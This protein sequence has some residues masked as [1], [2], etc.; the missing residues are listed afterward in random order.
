[1]NTLDLTQIG[2]QTREAVTELVAAAQLKPGQI[3][4]VG[5]STSEVRG[6]KIGSGGSEAVAG[7]LFDVLR[8][9]CSAHEV[10]LAIQCCE[11]LNRALVV[12]RQT[13]L[14]YRLE[15]VAVTPVPKAGGALAARAMQQFAD[16]V[17]VEEIAA[18]AGLDIGS[19]L[20]GMHL[21]KVAVPLRLQQTCIGQACL[22]AA[23]TRPKL[24]GGNRAVY[25]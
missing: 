1:M 11:H 16:P 23:R 19:T 4:V 24:I 2:S 14:E 7:V 25:E 21:K 22:T 8:E 9:V 20:I 18:H 15:P 13:S 10:R 6:A 3:L 17:V 5:C 12:E